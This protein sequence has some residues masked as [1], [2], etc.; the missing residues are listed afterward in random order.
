MVMCFSIFYAAFLKIIE[1]Y[2]GIDNSFHVDANNYIH[3]YSKEPTYVFNFTY[4]VVVYYL[5]EWVSICLNILLYSQTNTWLVKWLRSVRPFRWNSLFGIL[6]GIYIFAPYRAHLAIHVL[7]DTIVIWFVAMCFFRN[8]I[9]VSFFGVVWFRL[10]AFIYYIPKMTWGTIVVLLIVTPFFFFDHFITLSNGGNEAMVFHDYDMV[11]AM[12]SYGLFGDFLRAL[13]W[14]IMFLSGSYIL[15][16]PTWWFFPLAVHSFALTL[17][18]LFYSRSYS[19]NV[20]FKAYFVLSILS[21]LAP[22]FT[23]CYRYAVPVLYIIFL[24]GFKAHSYNGVKSKHVY[25]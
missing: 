13:I 5:G 9:A 22:G 20:F 25:A 21:L 23:T 1:L 16:S 18:I 10:I 17:M 12:K 15:V 24:Y 14:P 8:K 6:V 19:M 4:P 11:A 2:V 7:K 3:V